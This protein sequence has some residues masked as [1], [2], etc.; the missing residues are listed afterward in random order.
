MRT[1]RWAWLWL[2]RRRIRIDV[3][4]SSDVQVTLD[5]HT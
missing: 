1:L 5:V 2:S 3:V 4:K